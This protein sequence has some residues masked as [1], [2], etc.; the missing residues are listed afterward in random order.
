MH[1]AV[2]GSHGWVPSPRE[3]SP[4]SLSEIHSRHYGTIFSI[5]L[6][7]FLHMLWRFRWKLATVRPRTIATGFSYAIHTFQMRNVLGKTVEY[8]TE[9]LLLCNH[10]EN[11]TISLGYMIPCL[12]VT[13]AYSSYLLRQGLL[14]D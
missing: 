11:I 12:T 10:V 13:L 7:L 5:S 8:R 14:H 1:I 3:I 9:V 4:L 2:L 6:F